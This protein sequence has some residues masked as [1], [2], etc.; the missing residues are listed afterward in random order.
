MAW[1]WKDHL[2]KDNFHVGVHTEKW[3]FSIWLTIHID[4]IGDIFD[5]ETR[6]WAKSL[7]PGRPVEVD[8]T[9]GR[10]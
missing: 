5:N 10:M 3:G 9:M 6:E 1:I 7:E 4:G 2:D 8:L